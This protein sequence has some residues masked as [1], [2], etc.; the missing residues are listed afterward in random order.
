MR[1]ISQVR[2]ITAGEGARVASEQSQSVDSKGRVESAKNAST[3]PDEVYVAVAALFEHESAALSP[4]ERQMAA[5]VLR[6]L[7][8]DVEM[9]IRVQLAERLADDEKIPHELILMLVDDRIEIARLI[10]ARSPVLS[11]ADLLHVIRHRGT[12]HHIVIAERP[13]IGETV[14]AA[15][16][17]SECEAVIIALLRN[18]SAKIPAE[19]FDRLAERARTQPALQES[20]VGRPDL[21]AAVATRLYVWV[22]GALKTALSQRFPDVANSL[23]HALQDASEAAQA[24]KN[25]TSEGAAQKLVAKLLASGQLRASFLI[26]VLH[27]G[28]MELFEHG[29]AALLGMDVGVMRRQLYSDNPVTLALACRAVGIDRSVFTTVF[30]LSRLQRKETADLSTGERADIEAVFLEFQKTEA[31]HKLKAEAA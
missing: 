23:N 31:L 19:M 9:S 17:R 15:L 12:D 24:G 6:Q 28:Q 3:R 8:R 26:R 30:N 13:N 4:R 2:G 1:S 27:Q 11:D 16:A 21:P 7:S 25:T 10:L 29:F 18:N 20:L 22:T 14:S 5:D